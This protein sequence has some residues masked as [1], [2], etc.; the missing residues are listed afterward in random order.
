MLL[1]VTTLSAI[2]IVTD[3]KSEW[4]GRFTVLTFVAVVISPPVGD[5]SFTLTS[6]FES[7]RSI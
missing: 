7:F 2:F 3:W 4:R 1:S 6:N 5:V